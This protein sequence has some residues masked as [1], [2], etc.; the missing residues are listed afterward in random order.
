M[1]NQS[2]KISKMNQQLI[3]IKIDTE[4]HLALWKQSSKNSQKN[5]NILLTHGTFSNRK[6]MLGISD[7]LVA[8]GFTCWTFEW[9]N[10]G[11]SSKTNSPFN[12]E[13]IAKEDFRLVFNYLTEDEQIE[14]LHC[15]THSGGGICLT[16]FLIKHQQYILKMMI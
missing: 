8:N 12:F 4:N 15:I 7:F 13:T 10:H 2:K 1:F 11:D 14:N 5:R 16:M 9:R 6:V 3:K